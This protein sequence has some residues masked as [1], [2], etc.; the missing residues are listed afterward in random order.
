MAEHDSYIGVDPD[1]E[2]SGVAIIWPNGQIELRLARSKGRLMADRMGGMAQALLDAIPT[3]Y[4]RDLLVQPDRR[5][6]SPCVAI[7]WQHIRSRGKERNPNSMM[8]VQAVAGMAMAAAVYRRVR[9]EDILRPL[10]WEWKG[11]IPKEIHQKRVL[12]AAE[13]SHD[14]PQFHGIP[15]TMHEHV[16]DALGLALW[17]KE[18]TK[19]RNP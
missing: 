16:I 5:I 15:K 18:W 14:S 8:G 17:A 11:S 7:E 1:T 6:E 13:L 9:G 10:P 4:R 2:T 3:V 19:S 12:R